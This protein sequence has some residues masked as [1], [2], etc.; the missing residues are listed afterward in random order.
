M[1]LL[2]EKEIANNRI[3]LTSPSL[4]SL[5]EGVEVRI[6]IF[7]SPREEVHIEMTEEEGETI[8]GRIGEGTLKEEEIITEEGIILEEEEEEEEETITKMEIIRDITTTT[9][10]N[11][12]Q[13]ETTIKKTSLSQVSNRLM[14]S[15]GMSDNR[16]INPSTKN[17]N[18]SLAGK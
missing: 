3:G 8:G 2:G 5:I 15:H 9:K 12:I 6:I 4:D 13:K 14:I 18:T 17:K 16:T 1:I 7:E 10:V 11:K